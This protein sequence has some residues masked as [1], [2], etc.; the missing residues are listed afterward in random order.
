MSP[1]YSI[2]LEQPKQR[3]CPS[4][5]LIDDSASNLL[6]QQ[7]QQMHIVDHCQINLLLNSIFMSILYSKLLIPAYDLDVETQ[8]L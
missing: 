3:Q 8:T 4:N 5:L 7:Q 6:K 1:T 2:L